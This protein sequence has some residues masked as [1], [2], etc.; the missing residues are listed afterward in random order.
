[1]E[2]L[3]D[4]TALIAV[5]YPSDF[6]LERVMLSILSHKEAIDREG[7]NDSCIFTRES[8]LEGVF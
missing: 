6:H 7:T 3:L 1:M 5:Y 2:A 8:G 4:F